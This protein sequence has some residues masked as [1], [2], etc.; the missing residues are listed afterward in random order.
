MATSP[1]K[2]IDRFGLF[3]E[4]AG[5]AD[6]EFFHIEEIQTR[7]RLYRWQITPHTHTRM[8]QVV[9]LANGEARV[10]ADGNVHDVAGPCAVCLPGNVVHSFA[11]N[12]HS[13]GQ[14]VTVSEELLGGQPADDAQSLFG[15]FLRGPLVLDFRSRLQDA[16]RIDALLA[17]M[18]SEFQAP[19]RA[20]HQVFLWLLQTML[21][22][23]Q[24]QASEQSI[25]AGKAGFRRALFNRLTQTIEDQFR[26]QWTSRQYADA[27]AV[28]VPRLNRVCLEFS[29]RTVTQL[30]HDRVILEARRQLI[31]TSA[32]VEWIAFELGFTDPG[33][34]NRFF[35]RVTGFTPG[36][37]RK[38]REAS[39]Q[40]VR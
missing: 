39:L 13:A 38:A 1:R 18:G 19:A 4:A 26:R 10:S 35:K 5:S 7:S 22:L 30:V 14:V 15:D 34:F 31:Y 16:A 28:S 36:V 8:F 21:V 40:P 27:L 29:N 23:F 20:S 32:P 9:W 3:G 2:P 17:Q 33:Y 25:P 37:F 24:R 12:E 6:P 11:F